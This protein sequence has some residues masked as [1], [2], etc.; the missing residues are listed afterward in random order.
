MSL[1]YHPRF[2]VIVDFVRDNQ[3]CIIEKVVDGLIDDLSRVLVYKGVKILLEKEILLDIKK[4]RNRRDHQLCVN[5]ENPLMILDKR[6]R[7]FR[8]AFIDLIKSSAQV[9]KKLQ[10]KYNTIPEQIIKLHGFGW[11]ALFKIPMYIINIVKD[12]FTCTSLIIWPRKIKN[13]ETLKELNS[14]FFNTMSEILTEFCNLKSTKRYAEF[15]TIEVIRYVNYKRVTMESIEKDLSE[16]YELYSL[17][18]IRDKFEIIA[19]IIRDQCTEVE[20]FIQKR[21]Y[22]LIEVIEERENA[23]RQETEYERELKG[24]IITVVHEIPEFLKNEKLN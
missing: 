1:P 11:Y 9:L 14:I 17:F 16:C 19:Q 7:L 8:V 5:N 2:Q 10:E 20:D 21:V 18:N 13:K 3:P 23:P 4:P 15:D 12:L 6:M 22:E 24:E